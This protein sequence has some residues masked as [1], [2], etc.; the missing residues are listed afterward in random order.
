MKEYHGKLY[1]CK[2][3]I[4]ELVYAKNEQDIKTWNERIPKWL[5]W[6]VKFKWVITWTGH[7]HYRDA[8]GELK[9]K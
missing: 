8:T 5:R 1:F 4:L 7:G 3:E 6:I 2:I 9:L